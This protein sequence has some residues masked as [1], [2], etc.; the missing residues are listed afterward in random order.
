MTIRWLRWAFSRAS[1]TKHSAPNGHLVAP[2]Q[3][4]W[5]T[6]TWRHSR[7]VWRG[8]WSRSPLPPASA[9]SSAHARSSSTFG[10]HR[11]RGHV[12]EGALVVGHALADPVQ[13][14][15]V[16]AALEH[17]VR[18]LSTSLARPLEQRGDVA[19][20][21]LVLEGEGGR[22][23][24][25]PVVVEQGWA[26]GSRATCRCRCRPGRAGGGRSASPSATASA[27]ATWPGRSSPP[28]ASTAA[29]STSRTG[30]VS[31]GRGGRHQCTLAAT[32]D[33]TRDGRRSGSAKSDAGS[34]RGPGTGLVCKESATPGRDQH[35]RRA[36]YAPEDH[37]R[38]RD[39]RPVRGAGR[40]SRRG[41]RATEPHRAGPGEGQA[42]RHG[43]PAPA[44][45]LQL[46][47]V[48]RH[49]NSR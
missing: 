28:R 49:R 6:L 27:I 46:P 23:D 13:A 19:L 12:D 40:S 45:G 41:P 36:P 37:R 29:A 35:V 9:S 48:P 11:A 44:Q 39:R 24:H 2:R 47:L 4:R 42:R 16:G 31:A 25:D 3:S 15:V 21:E 33:R 32:T 7:S 26:R 17:G 8:A 20:D 18:R 10:A 34:G 1:S 43:P 22:R 30:D 14:G 5:P 38:Y